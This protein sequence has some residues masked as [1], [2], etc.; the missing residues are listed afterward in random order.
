MTKIAVESQ[1]LTLKELIKLAKKSPVFITEDGETR[2]ALV[3][4]DE[5]DVEAY[6]LGTTRR[7]LPICKLPESE[8]AMKAQPPST[9]CAAV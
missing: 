5:A 3:A 1:N 7:L 6:S 4:V 8:H 2:Y 9:R